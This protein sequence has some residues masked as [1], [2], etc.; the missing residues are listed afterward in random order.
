MAGFAFFAIF[1]CHGSGCSAARHLKSGKQLTGSAQKSILAHFC[2]L[3]ARFKIGHTPRKNRR[4]KTAATSRFNAYLAG[5][6]IRLSQS[7]QNII[8]QR[9]SKCK[10]FFYFFEKNFNKTRRT[11]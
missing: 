1:F 6:F 8:L 10:H 7:R 2:V 11:S 3:I 4:L 9:F 5:I